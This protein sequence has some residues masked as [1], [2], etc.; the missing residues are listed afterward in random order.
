[1]STT[2][3]LTD[4]QYATLQRIAQA[5]KTT[6]EAMIAEWIGQLDKWDQSTYYTDEEWEAHLDEL[7]RQ[8]DGDANP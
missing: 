2:I 1:M 5:T 3:E 6:P 7:D 8:G 4:E